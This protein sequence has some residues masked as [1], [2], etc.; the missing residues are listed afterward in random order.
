M[1]TGQDGL[2]AIQHP[3]LLLVKLTSTCIMANR[4]INQIHFKI[5][6]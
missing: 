4:S 3:V 1:G 5:A 2:L 6:F